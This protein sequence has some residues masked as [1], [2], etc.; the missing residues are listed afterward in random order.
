MIEA[1]K[2]F[3]MV[4]SSEKYMETILNAIVEAKEILNN[5]LEII[6]K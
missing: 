4:N 5:R 3:A 2:R 6:I 1:F